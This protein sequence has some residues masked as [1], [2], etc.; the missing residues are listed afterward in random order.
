MSA[1]S[2]A[3]D[4]GNETL[5]LSSRLRRKARRS[6]RAESRVRVIRVVELNSQQVVAAA[7]TDGEDGSSEI[8]GTIADS[9]TIF[10]AARA[11]S[12]WC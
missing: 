11:R 1:R 6:W 10:N 5:I 3:D 7:D 2:V 8:A 12:N 4:A 9:T